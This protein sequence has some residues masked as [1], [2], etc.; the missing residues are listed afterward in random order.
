MWINILDEEIPKK[1]DH[2][3]LLLLYYKN[4]YGHT[5]AALNNSEIVTARWDSL[6]E[7]FYEMKTG[8]EIHSAEIA[9]WWKDKY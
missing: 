8:K 7:A 2:I 3:Y 9:E 1:H 4:Y 5:I 6:E